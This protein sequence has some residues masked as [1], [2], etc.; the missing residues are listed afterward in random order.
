MGS[1]NKDW[2]MLLVLPWNKQAFTLLLQKSDKSFEYHVGDIIIWNNRVEVI[3]Y[4]VLC[5]L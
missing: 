5:V 3:N 4:N 1:Q 2:L